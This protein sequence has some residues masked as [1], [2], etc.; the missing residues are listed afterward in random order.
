MDTIYDEGEVVPP[1]THN[2]VL[3]MLLREIAYGSLPGSELKRTD[4]DSVWLHTDTDIEAW[5]RGM[6]IDE[7]DA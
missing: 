5:L 2:E 6:I 7:L 1:R 4:M 3:R